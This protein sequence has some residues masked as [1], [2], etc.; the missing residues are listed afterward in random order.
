MR[1]G[2][3]ELFLVNPNRPMLYGRETYPSVAA[4]GTPVDA[5]MSIVPA[6]RAPDVVADCAAADAGGVVVIAGGF[7]EMGPEGAGLE[8]RLLAASGTM[9]ILGPNCNGF[10]RPGQGVRLTGAPNLPMESGGVGVVTQSGALMAAFGLETRERGV[11]ISTVISTGNELKLGLSECVDFLVDDEQTKVIALVVETIRRPREFFAAARRASDAGKPVVALKLGR[12]QRGREIATS[13]TGAL[14][15]EPWVYAAAFRQHGIGVALDLEDLM[16]R[17][18]LVAQL[19]PERWSAVRGLGVLSLSG[20]WSAMTSDICA[21]EG[22]P[23]PALEGVLDSVNALIPGRTT[24]NPLDMTGFAM[25][26]ADIIESL[27]HLFAD[28]EEIDALMLQ[29]FAD[30]SGADAGA[31]ILEAARAA[32]SAAEIPIVFG[33]IDDSR[34]GSWGRDLAADGVAVGR[35]IRA[36]IRGLA[37]MG[38]HVRHREHGREATPAE[39]KPLNQPEGLPVASVAGPMLPFEATMSLLT[40]AGIAVAPY[41][42]VEP[43]QRPDGV[44]PTFPGPFVVK[45]A[46]VP[47]RTELGA[48]RLGVAAATVGDA[49]EELRSLARTHGVPARVAIQPQ[50]NLVGE[51]FLG[52]QAQSDLGPLVVCGVGGILVEAQGAVAGRIAPLAAADIEDMLDEVAAFGVFEGLRGSAPWDR[53]QLAGILRSASSLASG[54]VGWLSSLD[55]NPLA[56]TA[57]GFLALDGLCLL[58]PTTA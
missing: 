37:T 13:H 9:P 4:I 49:I 3:V 15:G 28:S 50:V 42:I 34:V 46:D 54:A 21:D 58:L 48:V 7:S 56:M 33:G 39:S 45:L 35:G 17:V 23:L 19:A 43:E 5:V 44:E 16:D 26:R 11:G 14:A 41:T 31:S 8:R 51:G 29:W 18:A 30:E 32:A 38:A 36:S 47:H 57:E 40:A 52:I 10:V 20:G 55:V 22:V 1:D 27:A 25:G 12:S 24:V 2:P 53:Q 6:E